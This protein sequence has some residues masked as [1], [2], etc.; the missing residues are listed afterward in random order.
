MGS[1][2]DHL[3][4]HS[5]HRIIIIVG[6]AVVDHCATGMSRLVTHLVFNPVQQGLT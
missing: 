2:G 5:S 3:S 6:G 1:R 4:E